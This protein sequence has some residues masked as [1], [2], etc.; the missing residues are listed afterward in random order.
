[1]RDTPVNRLLVRPAFLRQNEWV[2]APTVPVPDTPDV[3]DE[4]SGTRSSRTLRRPRRRRADPRPPGSSSS[5]SEYTR[6]TGRRSA[7]TRAKATA[8]EAASPQPRGYVR[9][10]ARLIGDLIR[11]A[12]RDRL[13]GLAG[14]N[15]FMA[16]LTTFPILIV[17]AA[18]LGQLS[19]VIGQANAMRVEESVL[20]FLQDLLTDSAEPAIETARNLFNT[21]GGALTLASV[22]AL[23]SLAQAFA[24]ILNTVTLVY[25]VN[26][27]RG[28]WYRRWL[29]LLI[30]I[31]SVLTLVLVVTLVVIG[32]L[33]AA[34][35][36]VQRFGL[37]AEYAALASYLRWPIALVALIAWAM[38][39]FHFCPDRAGPWRRGLPGALLTAV[40]WLGAS[41]LFNLYLDV[42]LGASPVFA[43]LGGGLIVMTW[44]YLLCLGL[45]IGANLNAI[46]LARH[47]RRHAAVAT[48]LPSA[49]AVDPSPAAR[50]MR[51]R[52]RRG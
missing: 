40:L 11:K 41:A 34:S 36:P 5:A 23:G 21:S 2:S 9:G 46:L 26:D 43:S 24:S 44:L 35:D 31:G 47:T 15:A 29:G 50:R 19:A 20:N 49:P 45:L 25:D 38:T 6:T 12:D 30:G 51:L 8:H 1:M 4:A 39:L 32:P 42:A 28:W 7:P 3:T 33:F 52:R 14:E 22:L 18:V 10:V 17:V 37:D 48:A 16:V 13:L 27:T